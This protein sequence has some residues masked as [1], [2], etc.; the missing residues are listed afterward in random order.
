M[1]DNALETPLTE[2]MARIPRDSVLDWQ[3]P[4]GLRAYCHAPVG[5]YIHQALALIASQAA[6]IKRLRAS[7]AEEHSWYVAAEASLAA[8]TDEVEVLRE[9]EALHA[10]LVVSQAAEI[11]RLRKQHGLWHETSIPQL[12]AE[13]AAQAAEIA[14]LREQ[15]AKSCDDERAD[16]E[17]LAC[18]VGA[19]LNLAELR[20]A[21]QAA[22]IEW[23]RGRIAEL[24]M[25]LRSCCR[26]SKAA[27]VVLGNKER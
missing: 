25:T 13:N 15:L 20:I 14:A 22:E 1:T 6:E 11:E 5:K 21:A 2:L 8:R 10:D 4:D 18:P 19:N 27:V 3:E 17:G 7:V 23:L 24:E 26:D 12:Y 16:A 9:I